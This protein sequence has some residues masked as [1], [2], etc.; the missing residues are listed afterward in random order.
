LIVS[1]AP[2]IA[3]AYGQQVRELAPRLVAAG[4]S[5]AVFAPTYN[6]TTIQY[7]DITVFGGSGDLSGSDLMGSYAQ[8]FKADIV[9][10]IKD[11]YVYNFQ[12]LKSLSCPWI[13]VVPIDTEPVSALVI[14]QLAVATMP[15]ALTR[16]GQGLLAEQGIKALYAPHGFDPDFWTLG[17]KTEARLKLDIPP[18][19]FLVAVVAANQSVPSRK[20]L[21]AIIMAWASFIEYHPDAILY[22]HTLLERGWGGID[23]NALITVF[24]LSAANYRS[25]PQDLYVTNNI[26]P[27][28]LRDLY[29]AADVVLSPSLGEGFNCVAVEAQFCGCPVIATDWTATRETVRTGWKINTKLP[30]KAGDL[31]LG[32]DVIWEPSGGLQFRASRLAILQTLEM[33]YAARERT[34]IAALARER[35]Q[36]YAIDTVVNTHWL[37]ALDR[38]EKLI[39]QGVIEVDEPTITENAA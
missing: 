35:V 14:G 19:A 36:E 39:K 11:P 26:E 20:N 38:I 5:V 10:T 7:N 22:L 29:R 18:Q 25:C 2:F 15:I 27:S 16:N 8:R 21:D 23:L 31:P 12:A 33:A 13:P 24:G 6:G 1:D 30:T 3:S 4:H 37:P 28:Y 9:L 17:D 34:D 32:G